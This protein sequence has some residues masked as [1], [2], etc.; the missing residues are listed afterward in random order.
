MI[1]L[2]RNRQWYKKH[3]WRLLNGISECNYNILD[4]LKD[5]EWSNKFEQLMKNRLIMGAL[6]YGK[7]HEDNKPTYDRVSSILKRLIN[8]NKTGNT[9]FLVDI[10]NL[11]LLEFEEGIHT[12]KHFNSIDDG[13]HV[14]IIKK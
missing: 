11:C 10:A 8:Y 14:K 9:E 7:I 1:L 2:M 12:N 13:E 6:R 4:E 5:T 3:R